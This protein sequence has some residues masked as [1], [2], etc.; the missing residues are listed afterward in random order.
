MSMKRIASALAGTFIALAVAAPSHATLS[1]CSAAKKACVAKKVAALLKCHAKNEKPPGVDPVKHAACIQKAK[2]KFD[3]GAVPAK[4]CFAKL[5]AKYGAECLTASDTVPLEATVDAFVDD[6]VCQ[7]DPAG[8]TCLPTATPTVAATSTPGETA[9]PAPTS[10]PVPTATPSCGDGIE[11]GGETDVDCGGGT[12]ADCGLGQQC[13][14]G[15]DCATNVCS[16]GF[17]ACAP[18]TAN[19][20]ANPANACEIDTASDP[21][22]CGACGNVC[23]SNHGA[24]SCTGGTCQIVCSFGFANCDALAVNGCETNTQTSTANCGMCGHVCGGGQSCVAGI[25]Q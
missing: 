8:G 7:L 19:C 3:G 17:C 4:G 13:V 1:A 6:V 23:S 18:G 22:N 9:T 16:G 11:N 2:D 25:C 20:D 24:P 10:T 15:A 21:G 12:C 5:E 14:L